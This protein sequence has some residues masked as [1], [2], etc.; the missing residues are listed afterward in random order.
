MSGGWIDVLAIVETAHV[1]LFTSILKQE[2]SGTDATYWLDDHLYVDTD[3]EEDE[4]L[5]RLA[6]PDWDTIGGIRQIGERGYVLPL[7]LS[8]NVH[9]WLDEGLFEGDVTAVTVVGMEI[10]GDGLLRRLTAALDAKRGLFVG[11]P[12]QL[13]RV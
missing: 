10:R 8:A 5:L 4:A 11:E 2:V 9:R 6:L 13:R 1:P 7:C 3:T 12:P